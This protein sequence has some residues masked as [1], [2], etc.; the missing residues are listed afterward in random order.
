MAQNRLITQQ[1][2]GDGILTQTRSRIWPLLALLTLFSLVVSACTQQGGGPNTSAGGDADLNGELTTRIAADPD[3]ID[4]QKESFINE[5]GVTMRVFESLMTADVKT[6]NIIP[7]AAKAQPKISSD[8]LQYTYTVQDGLKYSDGKAVTANDFRYG[9]IRLC[10]PATAGEYAATGYIVAGCEEWN[11]MDPKQDDPAKLAA[12]KQKFLDSVKVSGQDITFTLVNPAPYFNAIASIWV[13]APVRE[14]MVTK[15]GEKWTEPAYFIGNGPFVL[16]EWQ[17]GVKMVFTRNENYR[18]KTKLAKWTL[19]IINDGAVS[20]AAY[21]N[22]ELDLYVVA[23]EDLRSID[24]DADLKKQVVDG[25]DGCSWYIA[26]NN[27]KAPFNDKNVRVAFSKSFD[28]VS[29]ITD[30]EKIGTPSTSFISP[31]LPGHDDSD[32]F[33][34]Y[35]PAAAKAAFAQATPA[36][37]AA[38]TSLK[39][40]YGSNARTKTRLEWFQNQWKTNLGV[41]VTLDPVDP[42]TMTQ[43]Q[44]NEATLPL[45]FFTGWCPDYYDQQDWLTTVFSTKASSAKVGYTSKAFDDLVYAAD[46]EPDQKKRDDMYLQ[47]QKILAQD[48]PVA[49]THYGS[50]KILQKP[51]VKDYY[52]TALSFETKRFTDVY[53]TKKT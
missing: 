14:D 27:K 38:M 19:V 53:V 36:S 4:P 42:T 49:F 12:A 18:T 41:S 2:E 34:K 29:Y 48:A 13:G 31:G 26:F 3:Q 8:G 21:R 47:A 5:I 17:H 1:I 25:P 45:M 50:A 22:N 7:G 39:I 32:T 24:A 30:V 51:W 10:D 16:S 28:R 23:A 43:L 52:I 35:D 44:K 6:G 46:K 9:W 33:Q 15:G 11:G 37:Q 20:F 40:T